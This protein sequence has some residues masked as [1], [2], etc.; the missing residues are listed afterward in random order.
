MRYTT[1]R[2]LDAELNETVEF[3]SIR[4]NLKTALMTFYALSPE[5]QHLALLIRGKGKSP[6]TLDCNDAWELRPLVYP[7]LVPNP[8]EADA[9]RLDTFLSQHSEAEIAKRPELRALDAIFRD[10][11]ETERL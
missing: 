9:Q 11:V 5:Q 1:E 6:I 2:V 4:M 10:I 8:R 3:R 7:P